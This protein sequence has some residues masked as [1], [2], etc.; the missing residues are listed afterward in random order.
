[1]RIYFSLIFMLF[2]T[3]NYCQ[4]KSD[5]NCYTII[6]GKNAST[7]GSV[8]L[9]HNEDAGEELLVDLHKVPKIIHKKGDVLKLNENT[10]IPQPDSTLSY[11][12]IDMPGLEFSDSYLNEYG[13]AI[14]SNQCKSKEITEQGIIGYMLRK[15]MAERARTAREAVKIAGML[16]EKYGYNYSG[17]TYCIADNKE[18]WVFEVVK[19]K[20]WIAQRVP[21]DEIMIIPNYYV[22]D[23]VNLNDTMNYMASPDIRDYAI[24][25]NWYNPMK[26]GNFNFKKTYSDSES[27]KSMSNIARK[28]AALNIFSEKQYGI[29]DDFPFSFIPKRNITLEEL[30]NIMKNHYDYTELELN[31]NTSTGNPHPNKIMTICSETN[32]YCYIAQLRSGMPKEIGNIMWFAPRRPC[33]RPFIPFY[34]GIKSIPLNYERE[35]YTMAFNSH[36]DDTKNIRTMFPEH[37]SWLFYDYAKV[38]DFDYKNLKKDLSLKIYFYKKNIIEEQAILEDELI[39]LYKTEPEVVKQ[40]LTDFCNKHASKLLSETRDFLKNR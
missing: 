9:A 38:I 23:E 20:R 31:P 34:S 3:C 32:Q 12:W 36:F 24:K 13:V 37:A 8:F 27:L 15:I 16:V 21:D 30:M 17:R 26:D 11:L 39:T 25:N 35:S 2:Y 19:G 10:S 5:Y 29:H 7:D 6:V 1:M 14:T 40:R 18:G 4:I 22:I 28:W 33:E